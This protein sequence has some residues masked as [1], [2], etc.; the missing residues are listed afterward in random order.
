HGNLEPANVLLEADGTPRIAEVGLV[1]QPQEVSAP[2]SQSYRHE[3]VSWRVIRKDLPDF[4][5][6]LRYLAPEVILSGPIGRH[7]D[8][9][10]LGAILYH[11]LTGR[12]P[13]EGDSL[14]E[15]M[16]RGVKENPVPL[17]QLRPDV[18]PELETICLQCLQKRVHQRYASAEALAEELR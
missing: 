9:Y 12:P 11:L 3:T 6:N 13:F 7:S 18:P 5:G 15:L 2:R 16:A 17:R 8:I 10:G 4:V 1:N 14:H